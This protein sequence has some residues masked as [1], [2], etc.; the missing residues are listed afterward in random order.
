MIDKK[1]MGNWG[2]EFACA[3]L[4]SK[5]YEILERNFRCR[6]GEIDII[7]QREDVIIFAEVKTREKDIAGTPAEAVDA[8][9][10]KRIRRIAEYY[11]M[12]ERK[13]EQNVSFDVIEI[14]YDHIENAF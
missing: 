10:Q 8:Q 7:A 3:M 5:G 11:L 1:L 9:K 6:M 12:K 14:R 13:W 4:Y 2:E